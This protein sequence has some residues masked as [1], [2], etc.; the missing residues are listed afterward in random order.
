MAAKE[1]IL[2]GSTVAGL[3]GRLLLRQI[4]SNKRIEP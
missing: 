3:T 4:Q 1:G 2:I